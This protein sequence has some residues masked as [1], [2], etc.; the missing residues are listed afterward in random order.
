MP[1]GQPTIVGAAHRA[2][3][4]SLYI[5]E[6]CWLLGYPRRCLRASGRC[7][8]FQLSHSRVEAHI[9]G[10]TT[11]RSLSG[12]GKVTRH[13]LRICSAMM[14]GWLDRASGG[15]LRLQAEEQ[16]HRIVRRSQLRERANLR[17]VGGE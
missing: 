17:S 14:A 11:D 5:S 6:V 10:P 12:N 9:D 4:D 3:F 2:A 1:S 8:E 13:G 7:L 15:Y 16:P